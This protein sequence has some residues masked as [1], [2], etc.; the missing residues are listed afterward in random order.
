MD[1]ATARQAFADAL[2]AVPG[3]TVLA[4]P[5]LADPVAGHGWI[6]I[7]EIKPAGRFGVSAVQLEAFISA[8]TDEAAAEAFVD[9][10]AVPLLDAT[11]TPTDDFPDFRAAF[12]AV[13]PSLLIVGAN[14]AP[15]LA[16]TVTATMEVE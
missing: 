10:M 6:V 4:R 7:R 14:Q 13:T 9:D 1:L 5:P 11:R 16:L 2:S 12:V 3:I 8:G 15:L